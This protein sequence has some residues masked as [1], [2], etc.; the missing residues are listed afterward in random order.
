MSN[1]IEFLEKIVEDLKSDNILEAHKLKTID[2]FI[3]KFDNP[4]DFLSNDKL[5]SDKDFI[6]FLLSCWYFYQII[7]KNSQP[8]KDNSETVDDNITTNENNIT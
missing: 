5:Y 4:P 3:F 6:S 8:L 1:R 7:I 2:E